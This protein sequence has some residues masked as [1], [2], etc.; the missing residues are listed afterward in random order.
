[1]SG[2]VLRCSH[3]RSPL[4]PAVPP[5]FRAVWSRVARPRGRGAP[6]WYAERRL[7]PLSPISSRSARS[8]GN[9]ARQS[10]TEQDRARPSKTEQ[11]RARPSKDTR[12]PRASPGGADGEE[13]FRQRTQERVLARIL[14][15]L[16]L[17]VSPR[18]DYSGKGRNR[19]HS[20]FCARRINWGYCTAAPDGSWPRRPWRRLSL[21]DAPAAI[22][23]GRSARRPA[24]EPTRARVGAAPGN[25]PCGG[26][27]GGIPSWRGAAGQGSRAAGAKGLECQQIASSR[28]RHD[29]R[30]RHR[31]RARGQTPAV[32]RHGVRPEQGLEPIT[33]GASCDRCDVTLSGDPI[34]T[35]ADGHE[36]A[37]RA[38]ERARRGGYP[39]GRPA[40]QVAAPDHAAEGRGVR[41]QPDRGRG[42]PPAAQQGGGPPP[43][44]R[45]D[46]RRLGRAGVPA[47]QDG[48]RR[49]GVHA[50]GGRRAR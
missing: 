15:W 21:A 17:P 6:R 19:A 33:D 25:P 29:H 50:G 12:L 34:A 32:Q 3:A 4:F 40:R 42:G 20:S 5:L 16:S 45:A 46:D 10:E 44:D 14:A 9:L 13:G 11:D 28:R 39:A 49:V 24:A 41:R 26:G 47:V 38:G 31:V 48:N 7:V 27:S 30:E 8:H 1:M 18:I 22:P 43:E 2:D 37:L 36:R 23:A 35:C